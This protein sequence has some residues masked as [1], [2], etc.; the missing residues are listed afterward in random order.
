MILMVAANSTLPTLFFDLN[1][2]LDS[3]LKAFNDFIESFELQ[4]KAFYPEL[5]KVSL[6]KAI[7]SMRNQDCLRTN[8]TR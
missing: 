1:K 2:H 6:E 7:K 8:M 5:P 3:T 4:Y